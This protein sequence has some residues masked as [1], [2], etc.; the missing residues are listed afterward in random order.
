MRKTER[1]IR[2]LGGRQTEAFPIVG[3]KGIKPDHAIAAA[4]ENIGGTRMRLQS[5][6]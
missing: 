5:A 4:L 3:R 1:R 6:Y 2:D